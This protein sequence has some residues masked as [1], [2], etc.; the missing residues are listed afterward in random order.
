[1]SLHNM[2]KCHITIYIYICVIMSYKYITCDIM[3][4]SIVQKRKKSMQKCKKAGGPMFFKMTFVLQNEYERGG[5]TLIPY[6]C[7]IQRDTSPL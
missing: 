7:N 3:S 1:M 5:A 6:I 4:C 2:S